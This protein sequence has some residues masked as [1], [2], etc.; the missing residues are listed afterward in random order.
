MGLKKHPRSGLYLLLT[1]LG[2]FLIWYALALILDVSFLP[3]PGVVIRNIGEDFFSRKVYLHILASLWRIALALVISLV[4]GLSLG[5]CMGYYGKCERLLSPFIYLTY[6]VPKIALLPLVMMLFGMG[7]AAKITMLVIIIVFQII[8]SARDATVAINPETY[9]SLRVL[10]ANDLTI[11]GRVILPATLPAVFSAVRVS[12]GT[13]LSILFF[14]ETYGA[15]YGLGYYILDS[16]TRVNY[17]DMF[18]GIVLLAI[19]GLLLFVA[20]D[21]LSA[22]CCRW[23]QN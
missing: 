9:D 11:F 7:E 3:R 18:S 22:R 23:M 20:M 10:G 17:A 13:A 14:T 16:W 1:A 12:L 19:M 2:I 4:L 8:V 21:W 6:P 15:K 5:Y